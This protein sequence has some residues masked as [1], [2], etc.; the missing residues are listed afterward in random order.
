M[1]NGVI[2]LMNDEI[3]EEEIIDEMK[4]FCCLLLPLKINVLKGK[5]ER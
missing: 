1:T 2:I 3:E 5:C 4:L